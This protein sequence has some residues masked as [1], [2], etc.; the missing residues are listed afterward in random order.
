MSQSYSMVDYPH[1]CRCAAC[2]GEFQEGDTM[3]YRLVDEW[4]GI[5][6]TT[7]VCYLCDATMRPHGDL[8]LHGVLLADGR[9][10]NIPDVHE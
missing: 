1:G 4:A 8:P 9:I 3:I 6:V 10:G 5:P 2:G 7:P